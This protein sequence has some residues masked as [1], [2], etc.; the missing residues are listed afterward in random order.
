MLHRELLTGD[1]VWPEIY[2]DKHEDD[3][4]ALVIYEAALSLVTPAESGYLNFKLLTI[5]VNYILHYL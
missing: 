4:K 3:W 2:C 1:T 5:A